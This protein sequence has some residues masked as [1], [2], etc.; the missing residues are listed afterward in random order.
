MSSF[1]PTQYSCNGWRDNKE[2]FVFN[3]ENFQ[4][5]LLWVQRERWPSQDGDSGHG[6]PHNCF[7]GTHPHSSTHPTPL[8]QPRSH[9]R[10]ASAWGQSWGLG[11]DD[12]APSLSWATLQEGL[13]AHRVVCS[14]RLM[15]PR[16]HAGGCPL[17]NP[18]TRILILGSASGKN[19]N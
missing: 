18:G 12:P 5:S 7:G 19:S 2:K 14:P 3:L 9:P 11:G 16:P 17:T 4:R 8:L 6:S 13:A 10:P 15:S 1:S